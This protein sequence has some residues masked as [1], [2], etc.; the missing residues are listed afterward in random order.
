MGFLWHFI[1]LTTEQKHQRREALDRYA[2]LA[3]VHILI[4]LVI[5]QIYFAFAW[6]AIRLRRKVD[7]TAPPSSPYLKKS[8]TS[9]STLLRETSLA[10]RR[11]VWSAGEP[12]EIYRS[13]IATRGEILGATIYTIWLLSLCVLGTGDGEAS[14][15]Q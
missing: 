11:F 2:F 5:L 6:L 12:V 13:F 10:W 14:P 9:T 3:Q 7:D 8:F 4:P 1:D 15:N